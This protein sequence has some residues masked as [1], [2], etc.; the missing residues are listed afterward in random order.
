MHP[1]QKFI[2]DLKSLDPESDYLVGD[3]Y[4]LLEEIEGQTDLLGIVPDIFEFMEN[5]PESDLG[6]PGPLVHFLES[7][8]SYE[9]HLYESVRRKPVYY[10]VNMI[11]RRL[12]HPDLNTKIELQVLKETLEHSE[13]S[14]EVKEEARDFLE[15]HGKA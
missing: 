3:L 2:I 8:E 12:N 1:L 15:R 4:D 7:I 10:T 13:A 5:C 9:H 6:A 11:N 14:H